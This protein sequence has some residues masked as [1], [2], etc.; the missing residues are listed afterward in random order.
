MC[1]DTTVTHVPGSDRTRGTLDFGTAPPQ[2]LPT[3]LDSSSPHMTKIFIAS[4]TAA[5]N[6]ARYVQ[7]EL[8]GTPQ[9]GS[10]EIWNQDA[11]TPGSVLV[12]EILK[13]A[14]TVTH[15]IFVLAPDDHLPQ[16]NAYAPRDNVVYELGVFSALL[17]R[18]N[19]FLLVHVDATHK[20]KVP[21]DLGGVVYLTYSAD[22]RNG[23]GPACTSIRE[24]IRRQ[25]AT[26]GSTLDKYTGYW[27]TYYR[28]GRGPRIMHNIEHIVRR[29][30]L[31]E[32]SVLVQRSL[33]PG[34]VHDHTL[35]MHLSDDKLHLIGEWRNRSN[36]YFGTALLHV[37]G[38][39]RKMEGY[40]L[41]NTSR[42]SVFSGT[43]MWAKLIN[44]MPLP[45]DHR[46]YIPDDSDIKSVVTE[47][48]RGRQ[49]TLRTFLQV[50]PSGKVANVQG[51][52][53]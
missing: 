3:P 27:L 10:I 47:M 7:S 39:I 21:S 11:F 14:R 35:S 29:G 36:N 12:D 50:S 33:H 24:A 23:V 4:S 38:N 8:D 34:D 1:P 2:G 53:Q 40:Y 51:T 26:D 49:V 30:P 9:D 48:H 20:T 31:L 5:L 13:K 25:Q 43:W 15:A 19:C 46:F 22:G 37:D 42:N 52:A 41:G 28:Y 45:P 6:T 16:S 17:G 18:H 32:S 44:D